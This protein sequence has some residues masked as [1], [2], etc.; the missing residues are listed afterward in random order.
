MLH[1]KVILD[2]NGLNDN[3]RY[4][5]P[6]S[7][8][9]VLARVWN[10]LCAAD[11]NCSSKMAAISWQSSPDAHLITSICNCM[12]CDSSNAFSSLLDL[13]VLKSLMASWQICIALSA[14][15]L[16]NDWLPVHSRSHQVCRSSET[17]KCAMPCAVLKAQELF[18]P[19]RELAPP[20]ISMKCSI[21]AASA[22]I[23][24]DHQEALNVWTIAGS[25][26]RCK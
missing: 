12:A 20:S 5:S 19:C 23:L 10:L 21:Q 4:V 18:Q 2:K 22:K 6:V 15:T 13:W 26:G 24:F 16:V 8:E 1:Q 11:A 17:Y 9:E 3:R 7:S 14:I 25:E